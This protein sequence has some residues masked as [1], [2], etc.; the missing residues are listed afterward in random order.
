MKNKRG[1]REALRTEVDK[2]HRIIEELKHSNQELRRNHQEDGFDGQQKTAENDRKI[3][4]VKSEKV[5]GDRM[6]LQNQAVIRDLH[7]K[8]EFLEK[9]QV[10]EKQALI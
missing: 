9:S 8:I 3:G 7:K 2:C 5:H 4:K 10:L 1:L 6:I